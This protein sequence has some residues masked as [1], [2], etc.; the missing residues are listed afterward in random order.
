[1]KD[2][3]AP[4]AGPAGSLAAL[5]FVQNLFASIS[6][7]GIF[8][9]FTQQIVVPLLYTLFTVII[10]IMVSFEFSELVGDFLGAES[11]TTGHTFRKII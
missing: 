7:L 6:P 11:L 1:M 3:L 2:M 5:P 8:E 9:D 4:L 10:S